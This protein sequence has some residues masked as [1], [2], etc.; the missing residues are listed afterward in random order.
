MYAVVNIIIPTKLDRKQKALL[1]DL[2]QTDLEDSPEFKNF[3]KYMK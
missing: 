2:A 3:N 1:Q